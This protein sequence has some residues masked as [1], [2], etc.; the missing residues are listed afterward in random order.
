MFAFI[1][2]CNGQALV[3][4]FRQILPMFNLFRNK[5]ICIGDQIDYNRHGQIGDVV[6]QTLQTLECHGGPD[7]YINIKY[8]VPTYESCVMN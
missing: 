1:G 2:P 6:D 8:M 5:N 3:P 4:Y 7:A